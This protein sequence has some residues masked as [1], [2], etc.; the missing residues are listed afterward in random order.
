[1]SEEQTLECKIILLSCGAP[2]KTCIINRYM[3]NTF[4]IVSTTQGTYYTSKT[5]FMRDENESIKFGIWDTNGGE[6]SKLSNR[7]FFKDADIIILVYDITNRRTFDDLK[8]YVE[9]IKENGKSDASK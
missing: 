6:K 5:L 8:Y 9:D 4:Y 2:G 1:M 7:I 3:S